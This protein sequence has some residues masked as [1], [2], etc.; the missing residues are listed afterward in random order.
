M[1][2]D[3]HDPFD[4]GESLALTVDF[5]PDLLSV[6][7]AE[8][9]QFVERFP[10]LFDGYSVFDAIVEA[11]RFYFYAGPSD[12]A[13]EYNEFF[14]RVDRAF[15]FV[16]IRGVK[17]FVAA[18]ADHGDGGVVESF[19]DVFAL[20][21]GEVAFNAV[22]VGS[23]EFHAEDFRGFAVRDERGQVP[24]LAPEVRD[25]AEVEA[26]RCGRCEGCI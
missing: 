4:D 9:S 11:V 13:A 23:A 6:V 22:R 1:I 2:G 17:V 19:L 12:A 14:C 18:D 15:E 24:F 7:R 3:V 20:L 21:H 26:F 5:E 8:G 10:D 25:E 16:G